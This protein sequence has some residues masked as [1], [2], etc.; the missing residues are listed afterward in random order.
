MPAPDSRRW[1]RQDSC[2]TS[3]A[4]RGTDSTK[5]SGQHRAAKLTARRHGTQK[6]QKKERRQE[7]KR[8]QTSARTA[9][10]SRCDHGHASA[11]TEQGQCDRATPRRPSPPLESRDAARMRHT[12]RTRSVHKE[13]RGARSSQDCRLQQA[14]RSDHTPSRTAKARR[15]SPESRQLGRPKDRMLADH[16]RDQERRLKGRTDQANGDK[17]TSPDSRPR[18]LSRQVHGGCRQHQCRQRQ[19]RHQPRPQAK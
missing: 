5:K 17:Q 15:R 12:R 4:A 9:T 18:S 6:K 11:L 2:A 1:G 8:K 19:Q 10:S 14:A 7:E 13:Q 3:S 16:L